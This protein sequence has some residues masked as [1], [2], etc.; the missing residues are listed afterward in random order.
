MLTVLYFLLFISTV[1]RFKNIKYFQISFLEVLPLKIIFKKFFALQCWD[2]T[3]MCLANT[4]PLNKI[5]RPKT[6][7]LKVAYSELQTLKAAEEEQITI[8]TMV[9]SSP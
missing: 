2:G 4:L 1:L 7:F 9:L 8:F 3:C 6:P 5:P